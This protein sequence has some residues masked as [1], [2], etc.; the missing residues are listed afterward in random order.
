MNPQAMKDP[1]EITLDVFGKILYALAMAD[2]AIQEQEIKELEKIVEQDKWAHRIKLSF[3]RAMRLEMDPKIVFFK[4]MRILQTL[5]YDQHMPY[6]VNLMERM[7]SAYNGI[8]PAERDMISRF[9]DHF[10]ENARLAY[11]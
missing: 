9:Q 4:N 7:A 1:D 10:R 6:F 5:K 2:G 11:L 8:I 3:D